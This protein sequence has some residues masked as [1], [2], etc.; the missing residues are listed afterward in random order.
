MGFMFW[1]IELIDLSRSVLYLYT[2][3]IYATIFSALIFKEKIRLW[4]VIPLLGAFA[5]I[6]FIADPQGFNFSLG[7]IV[8]ILSGLFSL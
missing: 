3:P 8:G 4:M 2:Y 6:Y 5:G 7:D 1:A